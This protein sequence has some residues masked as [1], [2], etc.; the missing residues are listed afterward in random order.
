[1]CIRHACILVGTDRISFH[2]FGI[3]PERSS[4][5]RK[6]RVQV[7][8]VLQAWGPQN[9]IQARR[10]SR[11]IRYSIRHTAYIQTSWADISRLLGTFE[12]VFEPISASGAR[13]RK[14]PH[15]SRPESVQLGCR[16]YLL[17]VFFSLS[18]RIDDVYR[19]QKF[20]PKSLG[21]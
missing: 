4:E 16:N 2:R 11:E 21:C 15:K 7:P 3:L 10:S 20:K 18:T 5:P 13:G 6:L 12:P 9:R 8:S 1:M 17:L 14:F 19:L